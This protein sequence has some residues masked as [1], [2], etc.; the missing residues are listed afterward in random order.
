MKALLRDA[1]LLVVCASAAGCVTPRYVTG[2]TSRGGDVKF[3]Y[4]TGAH[5][6]VIECK[7]AANGDLSECI[8]KP[9]VFHN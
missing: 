6:G 3:L 4:R 8:D 5:T 1:L 2:I 9:V 7:A